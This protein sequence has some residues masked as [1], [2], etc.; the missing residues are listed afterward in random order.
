M[1][2]VR[3]RCTRLIPLLAASM[4]VLAGCSGDSLSEET[5]FL[6]FTPD[7]WTVT[8]DSVHTVFMI[9]DVSPLTVNDVQ[10]LGASLVWDETQ[11]LLCADPSFPPELR[12]SFVKIREEG[13][14]FLT[15]G[16]GFESNNQGGEGCNI[17]TSMQS[18]FNDYGLP[19]TACLSVRSRGLDNE[20]CAPLNII[21]GK[22]PHAVVV[23]GERRKGEAR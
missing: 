9:A 1:Y 6:T 11:V 2:D 20:Y 23:S 7:R 5:S 13:D 19:E 10:A 14:G 3:G 12:G 17:S 16:D 8:L 15:I 4:I 18:A 22:W 21:A